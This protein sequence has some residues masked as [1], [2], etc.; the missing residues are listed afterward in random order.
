MTYKA[1]FNKFYRQDVK[2]SNTFQEI[3]ALT[4]IEI[5][6]IERKYNNILNYPYTYG[7]YEID[8]PL[9]LQQFAR[10][11]VYKYALECK[12]KGPK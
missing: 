9:K 11:L 3:S 5:E 2:K 7:F 12:I 8:V 1:R 6:K 4:G 10:T